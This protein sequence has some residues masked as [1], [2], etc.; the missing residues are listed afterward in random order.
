MP[1][2]ALAID[3]AG[4]RANAVTM[5]I[6]PAARAAAANLSPDERERFVFRVLKRAAREKWEEAKAKALQAVAATP[7]TSEK[8]LSS[9]VLNGSE[10]MANSIADDSNAARGALMATVRKGAEHLRDLDGEEIVEKAKSVQQ[11]AAAGNVAGA[12]TQEKGSDAGL[13]SVTLVRVE[14]PQ[15]SSPVQTGPPV[16]DV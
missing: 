2:S 10:S 3:W 7:T 14:L 15:A 5:G 6:R 11:L 1:A 4:I 13:V 8:P 16:I 12:W 9:K